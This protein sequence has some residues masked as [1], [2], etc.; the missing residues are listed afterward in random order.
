MPQP[1]IDWASASSF[2]NANDRIQRGIDA[3]SQTLNEMPSDAP[4]NI[5]D[6]IRYVQML[7]TAVRAMIAAERAPEPKE[8]KHGRMASRSS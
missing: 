4:N 1:D 8:R 3:A 6:L 5:T 7:T 2:V